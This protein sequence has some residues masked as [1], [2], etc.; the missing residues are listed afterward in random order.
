[1]TLACQLLCSAS[2]ESHPL[3]IFKPP[4]TMVSRREAA[5]RGQI[6]CECLCGLLCHWKLMQLHTE[7]VEDPNQRESACRSRKPLERELGSG[8]QSNSQ[9][10]LY[11]LNAIRCVPCP[12]TVT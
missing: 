1:M 7:S 12:V 9:G 8:S 5:V 11:G 3:M 10:H 4:V 6:R 2:P